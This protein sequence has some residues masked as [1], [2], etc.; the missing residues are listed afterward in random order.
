MFTQNQ[1]FETHQN[2]RIAHWNSVAIQTE[3]WKGCG[4]YYHQRL[5][6]IYRFWI[7]PEAKILEI[8]CGE[9]DLI[10]S[11]SP[12]LGVGIDFSGEMFKKARAKYPYL[13]FYKNDAHDFQI[14]ERDFDY[15]I[16]SDILNDVWDVQ[17][18]FENSKR[19]L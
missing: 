11:L 9:G 8:G 10:A 1:V 18:V 3:H 16:L 17:T 2:Q 5:Q 7:K 6:Q 14:E 19:L 13:C 15:I 12:S 4:G